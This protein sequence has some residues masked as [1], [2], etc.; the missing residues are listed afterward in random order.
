MVEV[1]VGLEP[2]R[3]AGRD[4]RDGRLR[5]RVGL[6]AADELARDIRDLQSIVSIRIAAPC[7]S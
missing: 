7:K 5:G 6:V 4:G 1:A 2:D 3:V